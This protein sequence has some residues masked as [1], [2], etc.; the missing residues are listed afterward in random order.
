MTIKPYASNK[1]TTSFL[2]IPG[3]SASP[4]S[5]SSLGM[6]W[7]FFRC[8]LHAE[9]FIEERVMMTAF[10]QERGSAFSAYGTVVDGAH[11][12]ARWGICSTPCGISLCFN[13]FWWCPK[14]TTYRFQFQRKYLF[15]SD[16][17]IYLTVSEKE[18]VLR[19]T[20]I[21]GSVSIL[22]DSTRPYTLTPLHHRNFELK[23]Y[24]GF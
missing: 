19:L 14:R 2:L 15:Y 16:S 8:L 9:L 6:L 4:A 20:S 21:R 13:C 1:S 22:S 17:I 23:S 11:Q 5:S 10:M 24:L 3:P 7:R 18:A 12:A